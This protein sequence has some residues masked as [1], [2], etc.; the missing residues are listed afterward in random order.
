MSDKVH[1]LLLISLDH[2]QH[3]GSQ[4]H[5]GNLYNLVCLVVMF[6]VPKF[7]QTMCIWKINQSERNDGDL[8]SPLSVASR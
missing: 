5:E 4:F 7:N 1:S 3:C 6:M 8:R 2:I